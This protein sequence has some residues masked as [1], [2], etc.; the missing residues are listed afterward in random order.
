MHSKGKEKI[1]VNKSI[2]IIY[3][4]YRDEIDFQKDRLYKLFFYLG[5]NICIKYFLKND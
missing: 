1:K 2:L 4:I 3:S 5:L